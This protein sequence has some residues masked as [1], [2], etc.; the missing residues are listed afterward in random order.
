M[1]RITDEALLAYRQNL[2]NEE[3]SNATLK[4]YLTDLENFRKWICG[5][6]LDKNS[7]LR[8]I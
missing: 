5:A 7:V 3:K 6:D 1:R 4:K 2:I 8:Y